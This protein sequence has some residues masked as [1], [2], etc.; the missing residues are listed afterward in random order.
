[1]ACAHVCCAGLCGCA[2]LEANL[3]SE[4]WSMTLQAITQNGCD[5]SGQVR[6][7]MAV[8]FCSTCRWRIFA[9]EAKMQWS[10]KSHVGGQVRATNFRERPG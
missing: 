4:E 1:M 8:T 5:G 6:C 7:Y 9:S 3:S 2:S 10:G